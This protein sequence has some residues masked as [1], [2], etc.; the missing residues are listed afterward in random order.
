LDPSLLLLLASGL[1]SLVVEEEGKRR[2][3]LDLLSN[4]GRREDIRARDSAME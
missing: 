3:R 4:R 2:S 1:L